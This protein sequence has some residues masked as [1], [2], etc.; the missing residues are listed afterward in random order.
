MGLYNTRLYTPQAEND[1]K[2]L[3]L[4][5]RIAQGLNIRTKVRLGLALA[6][7]LLDGFSIILRDTLMYVT[8]F[9]LRGHYPH[10]KMRRGSGRMLKSPPASEDRYLVGL[11]YLVVWCNETRCAINQ[12]NNTN[13]IN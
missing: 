5:F 8:H 2:A 3:Q 11:V 7:A 12:I 1:A 6:A 9:T 10:A 4:R 13:Q